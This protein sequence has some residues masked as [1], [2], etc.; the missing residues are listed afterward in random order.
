ML[1][2][3]GLVG[4]DEHPSLIV[5]KSPVRKSLEK[6]SFWG[7]MEGSHAPAARQKQTQ[8]CSGLINKEP[9]ARLHKTPV[10]TTGTRTCTR[11]LSQLYY[12][13]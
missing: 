10:T 3:G 6:N 13:T 11:N 1:E 5:W 2:R 9:R 8:K 7:D 12:I 4:Y